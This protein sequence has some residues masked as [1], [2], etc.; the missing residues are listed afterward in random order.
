MILQN[1]HS[2]QLSNHS[3]LL[4]KRSMV[5]IAHLRQVLLFHFLSTFVLRFKQN[6][7][8]LSKLYD[9]SGDGQ[10]YNYE[11]NSSSYQ[12]RHYYFITK[13]YSVSEKTSSS[14]MS[15]GFN[16]GSSPAE[17]ASLQSMFGSD[18]NS[19]GE[20]VEKETSFSFSFGGA[21]S[22]GGGSENMSSLTSLFGCSGGTNQNTGAEDTGF[23]FSFGDEG[24]VNSPQTHGFS[25]F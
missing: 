2:I 24:K 3:G 12:Y 14:E 19:S 25:L 7:Q 13:G 6:F 9:Q 5:L 4:I 16:F 18:R 17:N 21:G 22:T 20:A 8:I 11:G 15:T 10:T 23:S 1:D